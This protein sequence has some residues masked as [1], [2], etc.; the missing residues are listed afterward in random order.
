MCRLLCLH[1]IVATIWPVVT[2]RHK[3]ARGRSRETYKRRL[4]LGARMT[5]SVPGA[6]ST[7]IT[8]AQSKNETLVTCNKYTAVVAHIM[9]FSRDHPHRGTAVHACWLQRCCVL[10]VLNTCPTYNSWTLRLP[11]QLRYS[12]GLPI[13]TEER[14]REHVSLLQR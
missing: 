1:V 14:T 2:M 11:V 3:E 9:F 12:W 10:K 7:S 6:T 4:S 5:A 8:S 13:P